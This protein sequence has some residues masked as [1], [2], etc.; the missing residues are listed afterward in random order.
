MDASGDVQDVCVELGNRGTLHDLV[1]PYDHVCL[2]ES[3]E[4]AQLAINRPARCIP[5]SGMCF[6]LQ[7][8]PYLIL[9]GEKVHIVDHFSYLDS[10]TT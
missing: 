7:V 4:H 9:D 1:Y 2:F 6:A 8:E 5:L 3:A 10:F